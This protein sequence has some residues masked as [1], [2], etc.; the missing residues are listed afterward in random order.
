MKGTG[1]ETAGTFTSE[2]A[3]TGPRRTVSGWRE[4]N[5][6]R[7]RNSSGAEAGRGRGPDVPRELMR[8]CGSWEATEQRPC[9]WPRNHNRMTPG[10]T[11]PLTTHFPAV[12]KVSLSGY[13]LLY[14][15]FL[16]SRPYAEHMMVIQFLLTWTSCYSNYFS[17]WKRDLCP[18][19]PS[20][21]FFFLL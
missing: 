15:G 20:P 11:S 19:G 21:L 10:R 18:K 1:K 5:Q 12:S 7:Q 4:M 14:I 8:P 16:T 3:I 17:L 6:Q 2:Q 13:F 9:S